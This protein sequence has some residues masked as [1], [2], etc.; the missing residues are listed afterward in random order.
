MAEKFDERFNIRVPMDEAKRR[1]VNRAHSQIL[2][3]D[4]PFM[5]GEG[6]LRRAC[7]AIAFELGERFD[8]GTPFRRTAL[9]AYTGLNFERTLQA[10]EAARRVICG[11]NSG[12]QL[13]EVVEA[14]LSESEVDL[15][16]R[17]NDGK[18]L[19]SGAELLDDALVNE[20]RPPDM[21]RWFLPLL[22]A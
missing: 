10:I 3:P 20:S 1:F 4:C 13:D 21:A 15:G 11:P 16:I 8:A 12:P 7:M 9:E 22:Y 19:P 14:M 18:F 17:W 6:H 5:L 2:S